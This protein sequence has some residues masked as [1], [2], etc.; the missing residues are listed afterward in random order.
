MAAALASLLP[1]QT[2]QQ[3]YT[4]LLGYYTAA[5][6][7]VT[8]WQVGGVERT[9]LFAFATVLQNTIA[10]Y[11][12]GITAGGFVDYAPGTG[13]MALLAAQMYNLTQNA[14]TYTVGT[15]TL[16]AAAGV[17]TQTYTAGQ[18]K[19]TFPASGRSYLNQGT[20]VIPVGPGSVSGSF[21]AENPGS[22]YNDPSNVTGILLTTTIPGVTITNVAFAYSTVVQTGSGTGTIGI[23]GSPIGAHQIIVRIDSSGQSGVATWSYSLD[24]AAYISAGNAASL[25]NIASLGINVTLVNGAGSPSFIL[26][27]TL[28][29]SS[30]GSWIT[31][32]GS[33][34]EADTA[35]ATRCKAR[36]AT[37]AN[38]GVSQL[39]QLLATSTPT[40]GSQVTQV[41]VQPDANINNKLLIVVAGAA[42]VLPA[43]TITTIQS[44]VS[45]RTP[46]TV[47]PVVMSPTTLGITLAGTITCYVSQ[48]ANVQNL[49][50]TAMTAYSNSVPINGTYRLSAIIEQIMLQS[51]VVDVSGVTINAAAANLTLGSSTTYVLGLLNALTFTYATVAG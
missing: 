42:G 48:L 13:W 37:L 5:G 21:V 11:I 19:I 31:S 49:I 27:D 16:T 45:S 44:Y 22:A 39:Y 47:S 26:G 33:D 20:I 43:G 34:L 18:L 38:V 24:G 50:Q 51:G 6:F 23:G 40:V 1:S 28:T 32:Q 2:V 4:S 46:I 17:A 10:S 9:R 3:L 30:P 12:P 14:A 15:I 7:P 25:T 29:A 35:L 8:S 41:I 36:W